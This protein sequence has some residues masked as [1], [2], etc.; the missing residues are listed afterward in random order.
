LE[1]A[2]EGRADFIVS[3]D[4]HLTDIESFQGIRIVNPVTFLEL[5]KTE[6]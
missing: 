2:V 6:Q 3:G 5:I 4:R 1:C